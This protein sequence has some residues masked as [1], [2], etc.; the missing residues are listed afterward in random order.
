[1]GSREAYMRRGVPTMGG[2]ARMRRGV[3]T[4]GGEEDYAQRVYQPWERGEDSAQQVSLTLREEEDY[5]QQVSLTLR[6]T[7]EWCICLPT[8]Y[9][10]VVYMPP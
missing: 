9:L 10:R 5:A 4:M 6:Y 7:S 3:P 8:V 2:E 1:M